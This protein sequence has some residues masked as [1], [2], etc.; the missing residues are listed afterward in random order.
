MKGLLYLNVSSAQ[1]RVGSVIRREKRVD[2]FA[3]GIKFSSPGVWGR[4]SSGGSTGDE[5]GVA[6]EGGVVRRKMSLGPL[7][8]ETLK[9][10]STISGN[11]TGFSPAG[12]RKRRGT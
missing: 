12:K 3:L 4:R 5:M 7:S 6:E 1:R 11:I 2:A 9:E 8:P 10:P